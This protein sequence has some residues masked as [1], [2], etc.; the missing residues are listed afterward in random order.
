VSIVRGDASV[1]F[2]QQDVDTF[3]FAALVSRDGGESLENSQ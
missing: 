2:L 3:V 1:G